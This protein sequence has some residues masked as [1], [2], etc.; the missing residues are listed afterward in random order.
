MKST[1]KSRVILVVSFGTSFDRAR[2]NAIGG[3]ERKIAEEFP[4][5]EIRRA[6]T[7][8]IIINKLREHD[9]IEVDSVEQ[10]MERLLSDGIREVIVQPTHIINGIENDKMIEILKD[11]EDKFK[12]MKIGSP[13]LTSDKDLEKVVDIFS[14]KVKKFADLHTAAVFMGHGTE[15][16]VN[17]VYTEL[18]EKFR[19]C[20]IEN[21]FVGTVEAEPELDEVILKVRAGGYKKVVLMPFMIVSGD[22]AS[23]D[24]AGL[25][26]DSWKN[27]F[28]NEGFEVEC[29]MKGL[30]EY[31]EIQSIFAEHVKS[32]E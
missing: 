31:S 19:S 30:G 21:V 7:S 11:Y 18:E 29:I 16:S 20:G 24:M 12:S 13:L 1:E 27:N 8:R 5:C 17:T 32:A 25:G 28:I 10:A 15:H 6:F 26:Q 22:H 23:N 14:D 4:E 2:K 3:I 9:G